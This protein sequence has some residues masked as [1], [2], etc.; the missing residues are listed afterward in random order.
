MLLKNMI[1]FLKIFLRYGGFY[2]SNLILKISRL[3]TILGTNAGKKEVLVILK[4]FLELKIFKERL[5]VF[6][7]NDQ[8]SKNDQIKYLSKILNYTP[9]TP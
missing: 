2:I 8:R 5:S 9:M 4:R 3:D 7:K 6:A 1:F